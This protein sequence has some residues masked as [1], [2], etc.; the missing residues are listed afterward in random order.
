MKKLLTLTAA[1]S[2]MSSTAL[3]GTNA[4]QDEIVAAVQAELATIYQDVDFSKLTIRIRSNEVVVEGEGQA[5]EIEYV[6][7]LSEEG[8][9]AVID[10][11]EEFEDEDDDLDDDDEDDNDDDD[12]DDDDQDDSDDDSDDD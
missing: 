5:L 2:L 11:E 3:A 10:F 8:L 1:A 6:F 7:A 12:D 4:S 9:G